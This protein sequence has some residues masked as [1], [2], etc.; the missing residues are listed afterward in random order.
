MSD[1]KGDEHLIRRIAGGDDEAFN[2]LYKKYKP[3]LIPHLRKWLCEPDQAEDAFQDTMIRVYRYAKGFGGKSSAYTWIYR[4]AYRVAI[5]YNYKYG[6]RG[7]GPIP[8][9]TEL[10]VENS[11]NPHVQPIT[12][13]C[14]ECLNNLPDKERA[15]LDLWSSKHKREDIIEILDLTESRFKTGLDEALERLEKCLRRANLLV[16]EMNKNKEKWKDPIN[17]VFELMERVKVTF[18]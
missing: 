8:E 13:I 6:E 14:K 11:H 2:E 17:Y 9:D 7:E 15:I 12:G 5:D 18:K 3:K 4:I 16:S 10:T 1:K